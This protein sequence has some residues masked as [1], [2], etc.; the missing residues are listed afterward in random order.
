MAQQKIGE[1]ETRLLG[2]ASVSV[3]VQ[4]EGPAGQGIDLIRIRTGGRPHHFN[5]FKRKPATEEW[6]LLIKS[7]EQE[8]DQKDHQK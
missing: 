5:Q 6:M 8:E 2:S 1:T 7:I 3:R 4:R